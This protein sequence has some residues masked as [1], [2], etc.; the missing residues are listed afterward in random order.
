MV[1]P[2]Y[3]RYVSEEP[4]VSFATKASNIGYTNMWG[5]PTEKIENE[6]P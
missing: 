2:H 6:F 4:M 3:C 5:T 1:I